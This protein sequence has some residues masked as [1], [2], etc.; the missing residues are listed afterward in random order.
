MTSPDWDVI[1]ELFLAALDRDADDRA[2]W[3]HAHAPDAHAATEVLSLLAAHDGSSPFDALADDQ[4]EREELAASSAAGAR[5]GAWEVIGELGRGGMGVV[6]HVRRADGQF[7][8]EGALK[9]L[10]AELADEGTEARFTSERQILA[11]LSHPNIAK[12]LDGGV[13]AS[14]RPYF[15]MERVDGTPIDAHCD[16]HRLG[17]KQRLRL[18]LNVCAAVEHAHRSLIVHRDLKPSNILVTAEGVPKLLD[19]GIAKLLMEGLDARTGGQTLDGSRLFTPGYASPEQMMG[20]PLTTASDVFQ[21]GVLLYLLVAG[22][23]PFRDQGKELVAARAGAETDAIVPPSRRVIETGGD[24]TPWESRSTT[25]DR[26]RRELAGDLDAIVLKAL[27][28]EPGHRYGS[29]GELADDLR[30]HL[31]RRPVLARPDTLAYR[32]G[33]FLRRHVGATVAVAGAFLA[34]LG[35]AI[36]VDRQARATAIERDRAQQVVE[37]LVDLFQTADPRFS[38]ADTLRVSA[39]LARGAERALHEP[40]GQPLVQATLLEAIAG[41]FDGL[42][43]FARAAAMQEEALRRRLGV[44]DPDPVAGGRSRRLLMVY[45]AYTADFVALDSL[46]P[47][48]AEELRLYERPGTQEWAKGLANVGV[49]WQIRGDLDKAEPLLEEAVTTYRHLP[50]EESAL[51]ATLNNLGE[52]RSARGDPD[53]ASALLRASVELRRRTSSGDARLATSL[54]ALAS[55]LVDAGDFAGAEAAISEAL[56]VRRRTM[57]PGHPLIAGAIKVRGDLMRASRRWSE[58]IDSYR[59]A[60]SMRVDAFGPDH[61]VVGEARNALAI[62]LEQTGALAEAEDQYRAALTAYAT[63][64]GP[65]HPNAAAVESNLARL[66]LRTGAVDEARERFEHATPITRAT[67]PRDGGYMGDV[68]SLG[69][70]YCRSGAHEASDRALSEAVELLRPTEGARASDAFLRALNAHGSC[71]SLAG[72]LD[73][74]ERILRASLDAA[75]DRPDGDPYRAFALQVLENMGRLGR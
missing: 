37:F 74:A 75:A 49:A 50:M 32:S 22:R 56:E 60:L 8:Q 58:A 26:L 33:R 39:V 28:P 4:D 5:F 43:L 3:V 1:Q 63:S 7:Q 21:L 45:R 27:R 48:S 29:A 6:Y 68:V 66:L 13:S 44:A 62:A 70:T 14:G 38:P 18:F 10:A 55:A 31:D 51:A 24:P 52:L 12:L 11:E 46:L 20:R 16:E 57:A 36:G 23:H 19:F 15:V 17:T 25:P 72:R 67:W 59:E 69:I 64:F 35:F 40:A 42:G 9:V 73:D 65:D 71:L 47:G 30:R 34:L 61:F 53:S 54:E 41:A 2:A